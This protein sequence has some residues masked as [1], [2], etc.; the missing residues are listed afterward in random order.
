LERAT[1]TAYD[2]LMFV[3]SEMLPRRD[4]LIAKSARIQSDI[5]KM[6]QENYDVFEGRNVNPSALQK[7]EE[8]YRGFF[9]KYV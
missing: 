9:Q 6:Y 3:L 1:T 2:P 8:Q 5:E 4:V 7:R